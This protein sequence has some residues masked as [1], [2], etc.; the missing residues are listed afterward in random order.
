MRH[1]HRDK[2]L[3]GLREGFEILGQAAVTPENGE[4]TFHDPADG[5]HDEAP[6]TARL[7]GLDTLGIDDHHA[8]GRLLP[9]R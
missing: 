3:A 2:G 6:L 4:R 5:L 1:S 8:G 9:N 7:S